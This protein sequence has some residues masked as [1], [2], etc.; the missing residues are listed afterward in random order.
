MNGKIQCLK[1]F[2]SQGTKIAGVIAAQ[3]N[4][5]ICGVG[6]AFNSRIGGKKNLQ[7]VWFLSYLDTVVAFSSFGTKGVA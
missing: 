5:S 2:F 7:T 1:Y 3:A 6:V 4:N